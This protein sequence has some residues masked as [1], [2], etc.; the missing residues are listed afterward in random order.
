MKRARKVAAKTKKGAS[1]KCRERPTGR[2]VCPITRS[3]VPETR[4]TV[5]AA[6][7]ITRKICGTYEDEQGINHIDGNNMPQRDEVVAILEDIL[8]ILFPGYAGKRLFDRAGL[9]FVV[10]DLVNDVFQRLT[11]QVERALGYR[12]ILES[13]EGCDCGRQ[14]EDAVMGLL[15]KIPEIR[16]VLKTDVIAAMEG[17]PAAKSADEVII[18]Y[19]YMKAI[20]V[21]R[22]AHEL[23]LAGVPLVPRVMNE[24]AHASTGIDIHPGARI[25]RSFFIDHG[26]GVV[27]GETAII[28]D[29]VKIYQGVTAG[30][31]SFPTDRDGRLLK[32]KKRHPNIEDNVT[33]YAGAT[34]LGGITIG[35][36]SVIGGN[37]WLTESVPPQSRVT[38]APAEL[39]IR[40]RPARKRGKAKQGG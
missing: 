11:A 38:M 16:D 20:A 9:E 33:I 28:G 24:Y 17:D 25:G 22:V 21:H 7:R 39:K 32:G 27:I 12:C 35:H 4:W 37:V 30:A 15:S 2:G 19:P 14:A 26:T 13:C 23:V 36:D 8:E 29:N 18:A 5:E 40:T 31:L 6:R 3:H 10:G 34:I 1:V